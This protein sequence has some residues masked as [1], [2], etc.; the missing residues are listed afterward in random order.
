MFFG[1]KKHILGF[2]DYDHHSSMHNDVS[3]W[4]ILYLII[5]YHSS[6]K[7]VLQVFCLS[8][9]F[10]MAQA[11]AAPAAPSQVNMV[12]VNGLADLLP[13]SY[14]GDDMFTDIEEFIGRYRQWLQIHQNRFANNA[15][16]VD[17]IK[18]V[19]SGKTLQSFN[20]I[21]AANI[22]TTVNDLQH[23]L[24]A[25]FRIAKTRQEWQK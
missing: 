15:E 3:T 25:K 8:F 17:A 24:F 21:P 16:R 11:A 6:G 22:P 14:S 19:L 1:I 18:Y 20:E 2:Q 13:D 4:Y 7:L 5:T 12:V 23:D 9:I 10:K